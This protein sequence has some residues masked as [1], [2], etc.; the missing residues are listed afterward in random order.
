MA[1]KKA[2]KK[3]RTTRKNNDP[4]TLDD[5]LQDVG[6]EG[7][8]SSSYAMPFLRILQKLSPECDKD[9]TLY[10][11]GAKPGEILHT[12]RKETFEEVTIIPLKY[13]DTYIE[14]VPRTK[15]GGFV[16]EWDALEAITK[17]RLASCT[18]EE[19]SSILPNGNEFKLHSNYFCAFDY[20]DE[21][22]PVMISMSASQ[23]K[24][25]RIWLSTLRGMQLVHNGQTYHKVN[26]RSFQWNLGTEKLSNDKGTWFGWTY[27][28]G[29]DTLLLPQ[30]GPIQNQVVTALKDNLLTYD[31]SQQAQTDYESENAL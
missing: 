29:D 21:W 1:R 2:A 20:E 17:E 22:E 23:L 7:A 8:T 9:E 24:T 14:W 11:K 6:F 26:I 12:V 15:G 25:S 30:I 16:S 28:V 5:L 13:R 27:E 31:R 18:R 10:I 3:K 19:F 4:G